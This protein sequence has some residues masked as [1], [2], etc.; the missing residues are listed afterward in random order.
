MKIW[1]PMSVAAKVPM[2]G[3]GLGGILVFTTGVLGGSS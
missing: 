1:R 2:K 3:V